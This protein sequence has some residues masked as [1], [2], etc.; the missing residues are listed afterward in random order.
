MTGI[1]LIST[2]IV[3]AANPKNQ[4]PMINLTPW[5]LQ[6]LLADYIQRGLL[7][8]IPELSQDQ[9]SETLLVHAVKSSLSKALDY[10]PP[11]AGRL[12]AIKHDDGTT[13]FSV[14]CN[15]AGALF[16]HMAVDE[17]TARDIIEPVYVP[18][19]VDSFFPLHG[20]RNYQGTVKPLLAVQVTKL[21]DGAFISVSVN[22]SVIDGASFFHFFSSWLEIARGSS[23][24]SKLPIFQRCFLD[25]IDDFRPIRIPDSYIKQTEN[26]SNN[27]QP[28]LKVRVF[29]FTK[30][31]ISKLK[32]KANAEAGI[33]NRISSLQALLSHFWRSVVRNKKID[34]NEE[35]SY[36]LLIGARQRLP[37]LSE[38][39]FGNALQ[40]GTITMKAKEL[41]HNGLGNAAWEMNKVVTSYNEEKLR[42]FL[43]CW[44]E[45][46]KLKRMSNIARNIA[47]VTSDSPR[48]DIYGGETALGRP[49]AIRS[50]P[51]NKFDG[52]I[53]VHCGVDEGSIDIEVC[54]SLETF[55]SMENDKEFMD[56][57]SIKS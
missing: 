45:C 18:S 8:H 53:T 24:L 10:F 39:Y 44:K 4:A 52:R 48:F 16:V 46:P 56:T 33:K 43:E 34:P 55:Q 29:H 28:A 5:D 21:V 26:E 49:M 42:N 25:A 7:F 6:F 47:V 27:A 20:V 23:C 13:S 50:G 57:V 11:L 17:V 41:L 31:V 40:I 36:C 32:E 22:H 1:R 3:Q 2:S 35:T 37:E 30:E 14:E 38:A 15:N 12:A 9:E 19:I 54:L 51:A